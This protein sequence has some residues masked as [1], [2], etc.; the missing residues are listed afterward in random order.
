MISHHYLVEILPDPTRSHWIL[1]GSG[2]I[3]LDLARSRCILKDFSEIGFT[4]NRPPPTSDSNRRIHYCYGS[5]AGEKPPTQTVTGQLRVGQKPDP[6]DSWTAPVSR[7]TIVFAYIHSHIV[8][9]KKVPL[10]AILYISTNCFINYGAFLPLWF[11]TLSFPCFSLLC[12]IPSIPQF[13][14]FTSKSSKGEDG[15]TFHC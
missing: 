15:L 14:C 9:C 13:L 1:D 7:M 2:K 8:F 4:Q 5:V 11:D 12:C 3:S 10:K 6:P